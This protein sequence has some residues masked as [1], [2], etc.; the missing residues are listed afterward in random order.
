[1]D[2]DS[3]DLC[4]IESKIDCMSEHGVLLNIALI[5]SILHR[6]HG[7]LFELTGKPYPPVEVESPEPEPAP[8]VILAINPT[9]DLVEG[10]VVD[11]SHKEK[12][13]LPYPPEY[14][15]PKG[16]NFNGRTFPE[17]IRDNPP[18]QWT[19]EQLWKQT[20]NDPVLMWKYINKSAALESVHFAS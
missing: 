15:Y 16:Y 11:N 19:S 7:R 10:Q 13:Y 3:I 14:G 8:A 12:D 9:G 2:T 20:L 1:M 5:E 17:S 18:Q 6:L 4:A